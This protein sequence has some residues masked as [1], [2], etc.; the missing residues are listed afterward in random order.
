MYIPSSDPHLSEY[1]PEHWQGRSWISGFHGSAGSVLITEDFAGLWTDS[2]YWVQ[3]QTDL[4]GSD[5]TL[6]KAGAE[7]V[8]TPIEW[9]CANLKTGSVISFDGEVM[10]LA[11]LD[12]WLTLSDAGYAIDDSCDLLTQIWPDRPG[13]PNE[14]IYEHIPPFA[15]RDRAQSVGQVRDAMRNVGADWHLL[16][17]LDD[18]AWLFNLRGA[19]VSYNPVFLAHA[20][21]SQDELRLYVELSKL[22]PD[23][24]QRLGK[25]GVSLRGYASLADDLAQLDSATTLLV[26]PQR[27]TSGVVAPASHVNLCRATNPS[28]LMKALKTDAEIEHVRVAMRSDGA[29]LCRFFSWF[30]SKVNTQTIT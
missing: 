3:A 13:L 23:L 24:Q 7:G 28:Q 9:V 22:P 14:P 8:A 20:L 16:S 5:F 6:M 10:S 17:S 1:L 4:D 18:I 27:V 2:R 12:E 19:D 21:I 29:A 26:D 25:E 30:D 15:Q 11:Q